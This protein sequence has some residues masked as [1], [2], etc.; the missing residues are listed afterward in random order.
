MP[1]DDNM[2]TTLRLALRENQA[3][4]VADESFASATV[5]AN[6]IPIADEQPLSA[7]GGDEALRQAKQYRRIAAYALRASVLCEQ[8]ARSQMLGAA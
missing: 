1:N 6:A 8:H 7:M 4:R 5:C 2:T 3:A